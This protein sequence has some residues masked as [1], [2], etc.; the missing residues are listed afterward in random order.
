MVEPDDSTPA[1]TAVA[2]PTRLVEP[3][4]P[5]APSAKGVPTPTAP[6][7]VSDETP[8]PASNADAGQPAGAA[9]IV[10]TAAGAS[11]TATGE[12]TAQTEVPSPGP[13]PTKL[14]EPDPELTPTNEAEPTAVAS[15][16]NQD[17]NYDQALAP[18]VDMARSDLAAHLGIAESDITLDL[19][20]LRT[21][22]NA[23][24]GCPIE[25]FLY[26]DVPTD[27]AEFVLSVG[28]HPYRYV[29]GGDRWQP[30]L[31]QLGR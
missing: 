26:A 11:A 18:L 16:S 23:A 20:E 6:A 10:D 27:G 3:T 14:V 31:C 5:A 29:M 15:E 22:P 19:A 13:E 1:S 7:E 4:Q 2:E 12:A 30:F 24:A 25:G 8:V 21:W 28:G 9:P 17:V